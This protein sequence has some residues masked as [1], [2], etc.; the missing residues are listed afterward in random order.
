MP[1]FKIV[2]AGPQGSGKSAISS[3]L[4]GQTEGLRVDSYSATAGVRVL[5]FDMQVK[6]VSEPVSVELWDASGDHAYENCWKAIMQGADGVV[7][8]YN[9]DSPGQDQQLGDWFEFFVH[10]NGLKNEQC[11]VIAL[12]TAGSNADKFRPPAL[13]SK[14]TAALQ[15]PE[16]AKEI[17]EM[18]EDFLKM[19]STANQRA[20]K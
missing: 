14:V 9:P 19:V 16:K 7:L 10:K 17:R 13:F 12:R 3:F 4:A 5:E 15:T 1:G 6:S 11:M 2:V 8:V 20:R 18:F